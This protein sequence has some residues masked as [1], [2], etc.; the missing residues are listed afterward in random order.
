[1]SIQDILDKC[2]N[3]VTLV[4]PIYLQFS[5]KGVGFGE[6]YF[7]E[8]DSVIQCENECMSKDRIKQILSQMVDECVLADEPFKKKD[9]NNE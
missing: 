1:M 8:K 4:Q 6:L 2:E 9:S 3:K 5:V 7:H